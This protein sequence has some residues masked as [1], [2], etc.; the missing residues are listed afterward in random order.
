MVHWPLYGD[1]RERFPEFMTNCCAVSY[2]LMC[3]KTFENVNHSVLYLSSHSYMTLSQQRIWNDLRMNLVWHLE[4]HMVHV[5]HTLTLVSEL[6]ICLRCKG[7]TCMH[8]L[9][10]VHIWKCS[11]EKIFFTR[12]LSCESLYKHIECSLTAIA[13]YNVCKCSS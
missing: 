5:P 6:T 1:W 9:D 13:L 4:L 2:K 3:F 8:D 11:K 12:D 7:V 10:S